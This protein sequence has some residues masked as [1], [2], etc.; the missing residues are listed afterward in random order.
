MGASL[1]NLPG[2]VL[3]WGSLGRRDLQT[4]KGLGPQ[5]EGCFLSCIFKSISV[6]CML[7]ACWW[8]TL[9]RTWNHHGV[10]VIKQKQSFW[11]ANVQAES[12][13]K[14]ALSQTISNLGCKNMQQSLDLFYLLSFFFAT[15]KVFFLSFFLLSLL[16]ESGWPGMFIKALHW[17]CAWIDCIQNADLWKQRVVL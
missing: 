2:E 14:R 7:G 11:I 10:S 5:A 13:L 3:S 8:V 6:I 15:A 16:K 12:R 17:E 4:S 1:W 9:W